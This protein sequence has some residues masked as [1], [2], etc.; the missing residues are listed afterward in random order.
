M[1]TLNGITNPPVTA[2][3]DG[4]L[5]SPDGSV[6]KRKRDEDDNDAHLATDATARQQH[7]QQDILKVLRPHDTK[8]SFLQYEFDNDHGT[9]S[10]K[11]PKL[12]EAATKMTSIVS[13]LQD[14]IYVSLHDLMLDVTHVKEKVVESLRTREK[15]AD[16]ASASV[17]T[18]KQI[19]RVNAFEAL[20]QGIVRN[21]DRLQTARK[22]DCADS[23]VKPEGIPRI[24]TVLTLFGNAP[25][26]KQLFSSMQ[27]I[28]GSNDSP[29]GKTEL[30]I[31]DMNLPNGL[32]A[33]KIMTPV[34]D[35]S[36]KELTF[37]EAFPPPYNLAF[38]NPPR[39]HKRPSTRDN[40]I[41][42]EFKDIIGRGGKKHG[43]TA[44]TVT[45][46]DW[47]SYS[48]KD[49]SRS[50]MERQKQ[51]G[52]ALSGAG[53]SS[54]IVTHHDSE[55]DLAREEEALF[56]KAYSSFAPSYDNAKALIPEET[57]S[58]L[59]WQKTGQRR[60]DE[61]FA[62]DPALLEEMP[63]ADTDSSQQILDTTE[64]EDFGSVVEELDGLDEE[65][66]DMKQVRSKTDVDQVL[67]DIAELL[68][69]LASHQ[70]IRNSSLPSSTSVARPPI[71]PSPALNPRSVK[72]DEPGDEEITTYRALRR[73]L[74]Y[75]V[76]KLPPYAVAKL[77]G[78]QFAALGVGK[79]MTFQS[80]SVKGTMEEDQVARLAKYNSM[81]TAAGIAA[82]TRGTSSTSAQHYNTTAQRTPAI[83][84]AANTRYGTTGT[85]AGL[86]QYQR[87]TS[88]QA[89]YSTP[90]SKFGPSGQ[91]S[92][93]RATGPSQQPSY[94]PAAQQYYRPQPTPGGYGGYGQQYSQQGAPQTQQ[95]TY[96]S[97][98]LA[99]FQQ[100][101]QA[102]AYKNSTQTQSPFPRTAS[103][104]KP[105][106][107]SQSQQPLAQ[108]PTHPTQASQYSQQQTGSGRAT[109]VYPS[110]QTHT[111][112]NGF[113]NPPSQQHQQQPQRTLPQ[114]VAPRP[115]ST[116]PQPQVNGHS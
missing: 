15:R 111:P 50:P 43:Y 7:A 3:E 80:A 81:A 74:C 18:L 8:P 95:P 47:L 98:P 52:R 17:E 96:S 103:P 109:P 92:K 41:T 14:G 23:H 86:S 89:Q 84:Q 69:K 28:R 19:Q 75:L 49:A 55:E 57:K 73:E 112:V 34:I 32:A 33:T 94:S 42:W 26:P 16:S 67:N 48:G 24:G 110:S 90:A 83:G 78:Q 107:G 30:P 46:G 104:A 4:Q 85:P 64:F 72:T 60:F 100:R 88:Q 108:R 38:L 76:L 51:R 82:L 36:K 102:A 21:E 66:L 10:L 35:Q 70:R 56:R 45:V 20:V 59:W 101:A 61:V 115:V 40:T 53:Q 25:T 58:M 9:R 93:Y 71:S 1:A 5:G 37:E 113:S 39:A 22:T 44:Q 63:V 79:L 54:K 106:S 11:K 12:L 13:K 2:V 77:D 27:Y 62:I 29:D 87:P 6:T 31:E 116:T 105:D 99:Q 91:Y 68:G 114:A 65:M 97:Q